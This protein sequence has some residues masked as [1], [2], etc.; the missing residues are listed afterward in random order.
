MLENVFEFC[1]KAFGEDREMVIVV[2]ELTKNYYSSSFI[3]RYGSK[4]YFEHNKELMFYERH[5]QLVKELIDLD[6]D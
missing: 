4:K 3:S 6:I 5:K 2:T 1:E